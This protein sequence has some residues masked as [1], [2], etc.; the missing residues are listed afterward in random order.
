MKSFSYLSPS[1]LHHSPYTCSTFSH[2]QHFHPPYAFTPLYHIRISMSF[3]EVNRASASF[4]TG[5]IH[6]RI[7]I[8]RFEQDLN[9]PKTNRCETHP[10]QPQGPRDRH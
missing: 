10:I 3:N 4:T 8:S 1:F 5:S 9:E 6:G 7:S 2:L